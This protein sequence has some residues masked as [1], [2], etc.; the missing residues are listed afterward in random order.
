[1][2]HVEQYVGQAEDT[3]PMQGFCRTPMI[4]WILSMA[5]LSWKLLSP[6][7]EESCTMSNTNCVD[8]RAESVEQ[9]GCVKR[10]WEGT[11][12]LPLCGQEVSGHTKFGFDN[13]PKTSRFR[14]SL[15]IA[16]SSRE[17]LIMPI[18]QFSSCF[19]GNC[20]TVCSRSPLPSI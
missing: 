18:R 16:L 19:T 3:Y 17:S 5:T 2:Y 4:L 12:S 11:D 7:K 20:G 1:M 9:M 13:D 15:N 10:V 14:A 8:S 6:E